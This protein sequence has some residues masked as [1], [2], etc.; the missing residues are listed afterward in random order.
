[1]LTVSL[2]TQR[3][4]VIKLV[5]RRN[6]KFIRYTKKKGTLKSASYTEDKN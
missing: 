2:Y 3:I 4:I 1:M 5:D 6:N